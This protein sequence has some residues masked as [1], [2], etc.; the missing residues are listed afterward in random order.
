MD[1]PHLVEGYLSAAQ[2]GLRLRDVKRWLAV[3]RGKSMPTTFAWSYKR[4][5]KN[6]FI[7][8]D[9]GDNDMIQPLSKNE[10]VLMGSEIR[11]QGIL[12][13]CKCG[14]VEH[15]TEAKVVAELG[16]IQGEPLNKTMLSSPTVVRKS[17]EDDNQKINGGIQNRSN[18]GRS[19][20]SESVVFDNKMISKSG[21]Q[22]RGASSRS[23][24][25]LTAQRFLEGV[26][27]PISFHETNKQ[28][29]TKGFNNQSPGINARVMIRDSELLAGDRS[30]ILEANS[31]DEVHGE[32]YGARRET[33]K[34]NSNSLYI[35]QAT[36]TPIS[37]RHYDEDGHHEGMMG[38]MSDNH[39]NDD[40]VNGTYIMDAATQT[41]DSSRCSTDHQ[42]GAPISAGYNNMLELEVDSPAASIKY[43]E[44]HSYINA[45]DTGAT[46]R[47]SSARF[48]KNHQSGSNVTRRNLSAQLSRELSNFLGD[49]EKDM[50]I[51]QATESGEDQSKAANNV[52]SSNATSLVNHMGSPALSTSSAMSARSTRFA[53]EDNNRSSKGLSA[54][55]RSK[56]QTSKQGSSHSS[57]TCTTP[58]TLLKQLLKCGNVDVIT[59]SKPSDHVIMN[60]NALSGLQTPSRTI[61]ASAYQGGFTNGH[62]RK[63][64]NGTYHNMWAACKM[65]RV[66]TGSS[67][68]KSV[69]SATVSDQ[70]SIRD[71]LET[72]SSPE[73]VYDK[74]HL[75]SNII[76]ANSHNFSAPSA[77]QIR[78]AGADVAVAGNTSPGMLSVGSSTSR[79]SRRES[80]MNLEGIANVEE[81]F[82][83]LARSNHA[84]VG[85]SPKTR[86]SKGN[87]NT[88]L[89]HDVLDHEV[90]HDCKTLVDM[91]GTKKGAK[92][93]STT[94]RELH[95]LICNPGGTP[96]CTNKHNKGISSNFAT[97]LEHHGHNTTS[98]P[99]H[100]HIFI[101]TH[102]L[103]RTPI[104]SDKRN[105]PNL[106]VLSKSLNSP[107]TSMFLEEISHTPPSSFSYAS[108]WKDL[109]WS[110]HYNSSS[111]E[112]EKRHM[113][114]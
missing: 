44:S 32:L 35:N 23:F 69:V 15:Q 82:K 8:H 28:L 37:R 99:Q 17:N 58:H 20:T 81:G 14:G 49:A 83:D 54:K 61:N 47:A 74:R 46:R 91:N 24:N 109:L 31:N 43:S 105:T 67:D 51:N 92:S 13:K 9:L 25:D 7:W 108:S 85:V 26:K 72:I 97:P 80:N 50:I 41:G 71:T 79:S 57:S 3:L 70:A 73:S 96:P 75:R 90:S 4:T 106:G 6:G 98:T 10:Y 87:K 55:S 21:Q 110:P 29:V 52:S 77:S 103:S 27:R 48:I 12:G 56:K 100:H 40:D 38:V 1:H 102:G 53:R 94:V 42:D 18:S 19:V 88:M 78:R 63:G 39:D 114:P 2:D 45:A 5:Y 66:S 113:K 33:R 86:L 101:A 76:K 62:D 11:E 30:E 68:N 89:V 95:K 36:S 104:R 60:S 59:E 64:S 65:K 16:D 93:N 111:R 34:G 112:K 22:Y 107:S 84:G